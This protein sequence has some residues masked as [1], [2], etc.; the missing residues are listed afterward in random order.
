MRWV[1]CTE[2]LPETK[3]IWTDFIVTVDC[4]SWDPPKVMSMEWENAT[5]YGKKVSRWKWNDRLLPKAWRV[6]AWMPLPDPY[7]EELDKGEK[8]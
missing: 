8:G 2:R 4:D 3:D 6:I 1:P 5:C 7:F